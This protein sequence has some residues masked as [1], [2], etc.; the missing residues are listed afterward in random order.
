[1]E[2]INGENEERFL[3]PKEKSNNHELNL[4]I[5]I[6]IHSLALFIKTCV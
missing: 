3:S 1:M 2:Q 6:Q 4:Q 5:S